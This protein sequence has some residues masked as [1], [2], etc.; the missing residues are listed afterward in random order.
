MNLSFEEWRKR[1]RDIRGRRLTKRLSILVV[2]LLVLFFVP[3]PLVGSRWELQGINGEKPLASRMPITAEFRL[4]LGPWMTGSTGCNYYEALYFRA[5]K[6]LKI[7]PL[8]MTEMLCS[9]PQQEE[10][11]QDILQNACIYDVKRDRLIM[12]TIDGQELIF[13]RR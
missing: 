3:P 9:T 8:T 7:V 12:S 6:V 5:S 1:D 4:W 13:S 11:F 10:Q 2:A